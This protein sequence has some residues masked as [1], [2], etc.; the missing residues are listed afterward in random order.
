M[1]AIRNLLAAA[2]FVSVGAAGAAYGQ[3]TTT[4]N[5][6]PP[7]GMDNPQLAAVRQ[8]CAADMQRLCPNAQGA[9]RRTCMA[10]HVNDL[11]KACADAR[12]ALMAQYNQNGGGAPASPP[13][14]QH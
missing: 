9:D 10:N 13:A 14:P 6:S 5:G 4:P 1:Q 7:G 2:L 12:A 11:S 3:S 8:A